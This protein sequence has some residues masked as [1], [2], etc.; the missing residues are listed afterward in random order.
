MPLDGIVVSNIVRELNNTI[1]GGR[2]DKIY[3]PEPDE[4]IMSVRSRSE[5][6]KLL[7]TCNASHP[8]LH[9]TREN[10][11]NPIEP[12]MFCMVLR[13]HLGGG[14]IKSIVQPDF[15]RIAV[16]TV[17][18]LNEMGD[19]AEKR[20][21]VEIM[22]K[23]SNIILTDH[24]D[25][26]ID[27]IKRVSFEKSSVREVLPGKAYLKP[28]SKDKTDPQLYS[29]DAHLINLNKSYF[30]GQLKDK[31]SRVIM[32]LYNGVSPAA[33]SEICVR[34]GV[35]PSD[36]YSSADALARVAAA[37]GQFFGG[38]AADKYEP[39]IYYDKNIPADFASVAMVTYGGYEKKR[40]ASVSEMLSVYYTA[41]DAEF[42]NAQRSADL[43]RLIAQ[44]LERCAKKLT[45][46]R[47]DM[48]QLA[49]RDRL[50]LYGELV[51]SN[52]HAVGK[53]MESVTV[54]N[55][56]DDGMP[57]ITIPLDKDLSPSENAQKYFGQ[58]AKE[59][60]AHAALTGLIVKTEEE[61]IYF[62]QLAQSLST[63]E[64]DADRL[65]IRDELYDQGYIKKRAVKPKK[66]QHR[67]PAKP[68]QFVSADGF[69]IYVG[70][71]NRQNEELTLRTAA[72]ADMWM[73]V[74]NIPGSHV[75]IKSLG[76]PIPDDT[77]R[78]AAMLAAWFSK[79]RDS[80]LTPVDYTLKKNVKKPGGTRP[81]TVIYDNYKTAYI[82]PDENIL[83]KYL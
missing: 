77:L 2:V 15:E 27:S 56:Y 79:A 55:F 24:T 7:L 67:Q 29:A 64:S 3:Q 21:I 16:L 82:T 11:P 31:L 49:G 36:T 35:N 1:T 14:R 51:T 4:I 30:E 54:V 57:E 25:T 41:K 33:A 78:D 43:K 70:K 19:P 20:L 73:H 5:N 58:Y 80:Q 39:A 8:R 34:A 81:G 53:G 22:G 40:Y 42:R 66:E 38:V 75:V 12:P 61:L 52:I 65:E 45:A 23:H 17:E 18:A 10:K 74:K 9:L 83:K 32:D 62:E 76:K 69:T 28:P 48:R 68:L 59:K 6:Y 13:K 44:N 26:I 71:N 47:E 50:K 63:C 60:R 72:G 46:Q 37:A